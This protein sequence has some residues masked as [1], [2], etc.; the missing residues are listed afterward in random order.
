MQPQPTSRA[1]QVRF[2]QRVSEFRKQGTASK[3]N[4][5]KNERKTCIERTCQKQTIAV[6]VSCNRNNGDAGE[7]S[8]N[9]CL[10]PSTGGA[11]ARS[12][13]LPPEK[14]LKLY[15]QNFAICCIFFGKM[16]HNAV[17][18]AFLNTLTAF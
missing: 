6:V 14:I 1:L 2:R 18:N 13:V 9:W 3:L 11:S 4:R 16:V 10:C 5:K 12:G 15:M 17:H 7:P 8:G